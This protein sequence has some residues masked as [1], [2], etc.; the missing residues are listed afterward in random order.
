MDEQRIMAGFLTA[1][2]RTTR[3]KLLKMEKGR[4]ERLLNKARLTADDRA[5]IRREAD[6]MGITYTV[7]KG[8]RKCYE[9]ILLKMY[10]AMTEVP[11]SVSLD[12][13][14]LKD[15]RQSFRVGGKLY[16]NETIKTMRIGILHPLVLNRFF[17]KVESDGGNSQ[18]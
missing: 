14:S 11:A 18:L 8:C 17:V 15:T 10:E 13:W 16:N 7:K 1:S 9:R 2:I 3:K 6:G 12:G 5:E 4:I